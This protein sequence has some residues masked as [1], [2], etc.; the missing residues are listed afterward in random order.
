MKFDTHGRKKS[1]GRIFLILSWALLAAYAGLLTYDRFFVHATEVSVEE[2]KQEVS[3]TNHWIGREI[4]DGMS[5][6]IR[7]ELLT[8]GRFTKYVGNMRYA[9]RWSVDIEEGKEYLVFDYSHSKNRFE[10]GMKNGMLHLH[11]MNHL[12]QRETDCSIELDVYNG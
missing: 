7:V 1:K 5:V 3:L 12:M 9:G 6:P 10:Y 11:F 8:N 2:Q 4:C